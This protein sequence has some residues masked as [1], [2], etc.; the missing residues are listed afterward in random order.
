MLHF[1]TFSKFI[2]QNQ[3][4]EYFCSFE[5]TP[6][7]E[8]PPKIFSE[9][10]IQEI[11]DYVD[12][13]IVRWKPEF[14]PPIINYTEQLKESYDAMNQLHHLHY[15]RRQMLQFLKSSLNP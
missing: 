11:R 7:D 1:N 3:Q 6:A 2:I 8:N 13:I 4:I 5:Y 15:I 12:D 14:S 10:Y 9:K